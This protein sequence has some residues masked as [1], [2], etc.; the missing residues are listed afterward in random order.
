VV[1]AFDSTDDICPRF[2]RASVRIIAELRNAHSPGGAR[3]EPPAC[4][5]WVG[6]V[7]SSALERTFPTQARD[8]GWAEG[9]EA[10]I[11]R[12][13]SQAQGLALAE[14]GVECRDTICRIRLAFPSTEY[15][16]AKGDRLA[17][18][19]LHELPGFAQGAQIVPGDA[20]ATTD[21]YIQRR[22]LTVADAGASAQR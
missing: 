7:A 4:K 21:Y 22:K 16:Q 3:G 8:A 15:Q 12:R 2:G 17:A 9:A 18:D 6:L 1:I 14:L 19:A 20:D 11:Q 5:E 13:L 10:L